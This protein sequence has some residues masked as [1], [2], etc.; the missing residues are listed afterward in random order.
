MAHMTSPYVLLKAWD[1]H[2]KKRLG[3]NFLADPSTAEMIVERSGVSS[4][5]VVVE[6]GSGFGALTVPLADRVQKVYAVEI[7]QRLLEIF[8]NELTAAGVSNVV[9]I[10]GD[11][12]RLDIRELSE[13][14]GRRL[15]VLGNLPYNVSSQVLFRLI[16]YR[17][18]VDKAVLMFQREMARRLLASPGGRDYGRLTVGMNY[19]AKISSLAQV[20]A[21]MFFPR[22]KIDSEVLKIDFFDERLISRSAEDFLFRVIKA[23]FG[24]RRKTL[25]NALAGSELKL[26]TGQIVKALTQSGIDP[27]RRAETLTVV[28]FLKLSEAL[29][30]C[31]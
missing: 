6:I 30:A 24:K 1:L 7:D 17:D 21:G 19:C 27:V 5:D 9:V 2:A 25:K 20:N 29:S 8:K 31:G 28:E 10:T 18:V 4:G 13:K 3:Q 11:I 12:L 16:D 15:T 22:P 23:A 26:D 14:E